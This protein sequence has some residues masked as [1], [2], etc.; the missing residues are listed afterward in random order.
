M[1]AMLGWSERTS[2]APADR[3]LIWPD[4]A[5]DLARRRKFL[6][7][8]L[9]RVQRVQIFQPGPCIEQHDCVVCSEK[10]GVAKLAVCREGGRAFGRCKDA[11]DARP[12]T[13]SSADFFF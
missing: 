11:F 13:H 4:D 5:G 2:P 3:L 8:G 10:A 6:L 7:L 9:A 1:L 12:I